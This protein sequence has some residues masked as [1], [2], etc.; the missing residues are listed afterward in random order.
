M[1]K[2]KIHENKREKCHIKKEKCHIKREKWHIKKKYTK[3]D[4]NPQAN[5]DWNPNCHPIIGI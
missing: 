2:N 1:E 4:L 3:W 5:S